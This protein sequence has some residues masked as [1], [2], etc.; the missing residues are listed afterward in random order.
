ML[1]FECFGAW[2]VYAFNS[3]RAKAKSCQPRLVAPTAERF[4]TIP[5]FCSRNAACNL[6]SSSSSPKSESLTCFL[7]YLR[8]PDLRA[9]DP[10]SLVAIGLAFTARDA[11]SSSTSLEPESLIC[12]LTSLTC[13]RQILGGRASFRLLQL[14]LD[15][16]LL[17][18]LLGSSS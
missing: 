15:W 13:S 10:S 9:N 16:P 6:S 17:L 1:L 8:Q 18:N 2:Q 5:R 3:A 7:T 4:S 11:P 14:R 12:L